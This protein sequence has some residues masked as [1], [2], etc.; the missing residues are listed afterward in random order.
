M[1]ALGLINIHLIFNE[2]VDGAHLEVVFLENGVA[3]LLR[4]AGFES[5]GDFAI[6]NMKQ[7]SVGLAKSDGRRAF[8]LVWGGG[9]TFAQ[10]YV[11]MRSAGARHQPGSVD[12][13]AVGVDGGPDRHGTRGGVSHDFGFEWLE[14]N[15]F[16]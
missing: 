12:R 8:L 14:F 3:R 16:F 5:N 9:V 6:N 2:R 10:T 13:V 1:L 15:A 11:E 4:C 7:S